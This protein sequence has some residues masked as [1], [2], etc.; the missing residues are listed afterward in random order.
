[1]A[2]NPYRSPQTSNLPAAAAKV[3]YTL[4]GFGALWSV[5][6]AFPIAAIIALVYGFPIP[7][8]GKLKGPAAIF[9]SQVAVFMYGMIGGFVV[10]AVLGAA[11]GVIA[12]RLAPTDRPR[13]RRLCLLFSLIA[14][15]AC[16]MLLATLD[17]IIGPW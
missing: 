1:M 10:L 11:G 5:L 9:P 14:T 15:T 17:L 7:F 12:R 13:A 2:E 3:R 16:L 8:T 6:A 4:A